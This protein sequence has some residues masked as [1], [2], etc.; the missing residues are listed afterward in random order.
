[1]DFFNGFNIYKRIFFYL[2]LVLIFNIKFL[3][4]NLLHKIIK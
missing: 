4:L 3:I 2:I 1:M